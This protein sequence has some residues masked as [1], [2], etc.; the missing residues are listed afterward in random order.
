MMPFRDISTKQYFLK[1]KILIFKKRKGKRERKTGNKN[2][3][4]SPGN[5][6]GSGANGRLECASFGFW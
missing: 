5:C 2:W 6:R 4:D 1:M 3:G